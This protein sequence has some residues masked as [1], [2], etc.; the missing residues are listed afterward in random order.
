MITKKLNKVLYV[1]NNRR[2]KMFNKKL[3]KLLHVTNNRCYFGIKITKT[4]F[5][6]KPRIFFLFCDLDFIDLLGNF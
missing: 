5:Q 4:V 6:E 1:T 2:R 3:Y